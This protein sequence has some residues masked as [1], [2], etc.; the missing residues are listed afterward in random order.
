MTK[1]PFGANR[2][3]LCLTQLPRQ[4]ASSPVALIGQLKNLSGNL[5]FHQGHFKLN[6]GSVQCA[7]KKL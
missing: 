5:E 4:T 7:E 1:K 3:N 6:V 2:H